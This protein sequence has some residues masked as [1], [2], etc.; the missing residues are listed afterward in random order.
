[1][2]DEE[3][4]LE[5]TDEENENENENEKKP[6]LIKKIGKKKLVIV[7]VGVLVLLLAIGTPI[8]IFTMN[9]GGEKSDTLDAGAVNGEY[10]EEDVPEGYDDED[11]YE[12]DEDEEP[13]GAIYPLETFVV[14][15]ADGDSYLRV[16][17]QIEFFKREVPKRFYVR[18][19]PIRDALLGIMTAKKPEEVSGP[20][21]KGELKSDI[22][23]KINEL[24][25][26]EE[27]KKV[28]FTQFIVQ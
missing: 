27:V 7:V 2:V 16:Q 9:G 3:N 20:D 21:G 19:V 13:L 25:K 22:K 12:Y 1:V 10:G 14:N 8:V 6:S 26:K 11:E 18:I 17:V 15:L 24:M 4:D 23:E 5:D 28:Y